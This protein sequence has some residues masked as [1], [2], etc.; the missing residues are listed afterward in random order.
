MRSILYRHSH[1]LAEHLD[2]SGAITAKCSP[3][4]M[5]SGQTQASREF[6]ISECKLQTTK[7]DLATAYCNIEVISVTPGVT[8]VCFH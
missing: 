1:S 5:T 4:D 7:L 8:S 6:L 3:L 2:I